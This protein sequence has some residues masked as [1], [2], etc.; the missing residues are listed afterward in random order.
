MRSLLRNPRAPSRGT[1]KEFV[2]QL[3]K[4][5]QPEEETTSSVDPISAESL[6]DAAQLG[7]RIRRLRLKRSMGLV[8]LGKL[9]GLSA[10]F[11]SQLETGRVVP[12]LRNLARLALVFQKDLS[13][14]FQAS[15]Q[16][17]FRIQR[18]RDRVRLKMGAPDVHYIAESFGILIPEGGIR[19]CMAEFLPGDDHTFRPDPY[20]G[21][22]MVYIT[23]GT[24]ELD[25]NGESHLLQERDV[26]YIGGETH[27]AYR[28]SGK[29]AA[30]ALIISFEGSSS[31]TPK[32]AGRRLAN[33]PIA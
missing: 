23:E 1:R 6:L 10:S 20:S 12:T 14:F 7:Q 16:G 11:L 27:R 33:T 4:N 15:E 19:P 26:L 2:P 5:T 18:G 24:L 28:C 32:S 13:Y 25:R 9:T 30:R 22:E 29:Q 3:S 31:P 17:I 21:V 8:E